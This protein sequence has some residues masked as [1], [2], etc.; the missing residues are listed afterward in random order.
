MRTPYCPTCGYNLTGLEE[1][2]C[3]ECGA[4][5]NIEQILAERHKAE[6]IIS[7]T[8]GRLFTWP[9]IYA[10]VVITVLWINAY[11][12]DHVPPGWASVVFVLSVLAVFLLLICSG[13]WLGRR[14]AW[15]LRIKVTPN[16]SQRPPKAAWKY[17]LAYSIILIALT[18]VDLVLAGPV[19]GRLI[20]FYRWF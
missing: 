14:H 4:G 7:R 2:R 17:V 18:L 11:V 19:I 9:L 10:P 16:L 12:R 5:F 15:A 6:L 3:P 8:R 1:N 20:Y 13:W